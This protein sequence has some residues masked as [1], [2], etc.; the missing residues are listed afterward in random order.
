MA[1]FRRIISYLYRIIARKTGQKDGKQL[2]RDGEKNEEY[3]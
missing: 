1:I 2:D 3:M